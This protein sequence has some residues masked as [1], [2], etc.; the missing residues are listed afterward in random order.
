MFASMKNC[1]KSREKGRRLQNEENFDELN[2]IFIK[3]N[4]QYKSY[5]HERFLESLRFLIFLFYSFFTRAN[6]STCDAF[7]HLTPPDR[8]NPKYYRCVKN[9]RKS[10]SF[11]VSLSLPMK[12]NEMYYSF[13]L[14]I[15]TFSGRF[16][17]TKWISGFESQSKTKNYMNFYVKHRTADDVV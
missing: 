13:Y 1:K 17:T 12:R 8:S 4:G 9:R 11:S 6:K 16:D 10:C 7:T 2:W 15:H 3:M 5:K 14:V